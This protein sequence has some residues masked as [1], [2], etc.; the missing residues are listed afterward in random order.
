MFIIFKYDLCHIYC[1]GK[2]N[3]YKIS[4]FLSY[5]FTAF[6]SQPIS[7][8]TSNF[9]FD[10]LAIFCVSFLSHLDQHGCNI[11]IS[12]FQSF[13]VPSN[14]PKQEK[15]TS[16]SKIL[17]IFNFMV[18]SRLVGSWAILPYKEHEPQLCRTIKLLPDWKH[19][20]NNN[21]TRKL[22]PG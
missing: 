14:I 5:S 2:K 12:I 18:P 20:C 15:D 22:L 1:F 7:T 4:L 21:W 19:W 17:T 9:T 3:C 11:L 10:L 8:A 6:S 13:I 16:S